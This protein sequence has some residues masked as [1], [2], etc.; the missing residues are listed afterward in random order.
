M[1]NQMNQ[2]LLM[3]CEMWPRNIRIQQITEADH[4]LWIFPNLRQQFHIP[5]EELSIQFATFSLSVL[6]KTQRKS[7]IV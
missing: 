1:W 5:I 3:L 4:N 6:D 7:W 2:V